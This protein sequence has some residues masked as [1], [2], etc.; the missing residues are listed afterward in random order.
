MAR[1]KSSSAIL[2]EQEVIECA[3]NQYTGQLLGCN[4]GEFRTSSQLNFFIKFYS[5][6]W[7]YSAYNHARDKNGI[8]TQANRPYRGNT[9]SACYT[10]TSRTP[11][12]K[13]ATYYVVPANN[14]ESM[15]NYLVNNGPLYVTFHVSNDF[16]SYKSGVYTD[17]YGYCNGKT[18]N[19]AVLLV[20]Y[21]NQNGVDYWLIKNSWGTGFGENGYFKMERGR[22]R[23]GIAK[24]VNYPSLA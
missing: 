17:K 21:G 16:F 14:E 13:V 19:H 5:L 20:G 1:K 22:N 24:T 6:G 4:G 9:N 2:S 23:C 8:T 18:N 15:Q 3:R 11:G 10:S 12:S 7:H